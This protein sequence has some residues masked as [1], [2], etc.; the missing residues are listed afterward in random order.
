MNFV[1]NIVLHLS[2]FAVTSARAVLQRALA[3][4][5]VLGFLEA[6]LQSLV[7]FLPNRHRLSLLTRQRLLVLLNLTMQPLRHL[8][9]LVVV[10][11]HEALLEFSRTENQTNFCTGFFIVLL[12]NLLLIQ[13]MR[14]RLVDILRCIVELKLLKSI[15]LLLLIGQ[16]VR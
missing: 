7:Q 3:V 9:L 11:L 1:E 13:T 10:H 16:I 15:T 14:A 8:F 12:L 6:L 4:S 2:V 5:T